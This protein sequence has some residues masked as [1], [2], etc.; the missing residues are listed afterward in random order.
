MEKNQHF[1]P[2]TEDG[3]P[4][5]KLFISNLADRTSFK[6]LTK[7]FSKYG[8]VETCYV[9]KNSK[10]NNY[11]F[12]T[13]NSVDAAVRARYEEIRLH[14]RD[15]KILA[16]DSWHQPDSIENQYYNVVKDKS[17]FNKVSNDTCN[18]DYVQDNISIQT[19]ND[20]CLMQIFLQLPIVDRIRIERVCKRWKAL[21]QE[22]WHSVK[23][24]DLSYSIWGCLSGINRKEIS[25]CTIR[26]VL[27]RCGSYLNEIN[28]SLVPCHLRQSTVTVVAKLCPNLQIIDI[29]GLTVSTSGINSLITNC[30]YITKFSLGPTSYVCDADLQKLFYVN[31]KLRYFRFSGTKMSGRCLF[32]LPLETMEEIVLESCTYLQEHFLSQAIPKLR[33]LRALTISKCVYITG[34]VIQA[35]GTHCTNLKTLEVSSILFSLQSDDMLHIAQLTNL[36]V[37]KLS[38][39]TVVTDLLLS[40]LASKCLCLTYLDIAECFLVTNAGI[41]AIATLPKLE[42]LIMNNLRLVTH[43]NLRDTSNL[44]RLECRVCK[45]TDRMIINLIESAPQ[46]RLLDLSGCP[47]ITNRTLEKAATLTVSRTNNTVL[48]IFVG[49]T[50]VD[51]S[52]FNKVSPFLQV[53]NVD[54]SSCNG[55]VTFPLVL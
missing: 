37:L 10:N 38:M 6:D 40:T 4:I 46:L 24:L 19:L 8:D 21:S 47:Y 51:L 31:P 45:F 49:K 44:K 41:T 55:T 50:S 25:I 17:K 35:I 11:A 12:V 32:H 20:D 14:N 2:V 9:K 3:V 22:S 18:L 33:N 52:T 15:L 42:V 1:S 39:N 23:R 28:L 36:E 29:T 53:V 13:F 43:I 26:K 5:R 16:A 48:K 30:H 34:N 7:L 27:L 54:L